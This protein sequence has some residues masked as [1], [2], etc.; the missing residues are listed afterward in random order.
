MKFLPSFF[1]Q[2]LFDIDTHQRGGDQRGNCHRPENR[3][4]AENR[5]QQSPEHR[6]QQRCDGHDQHHKRHHSREFVFGEHIA[7]QRIDNDTGGGGGKTMQEAHPDQLFDRLRQRTGT[8]SDGK[9]QHAP[10]DN[11]LT[12][13]AVRHRSVKQL[14]YRKTQHIGAERHLHTARRN[15]IF[16]R[17]D[18]HTWQIHIDGQ[19]H[20]HRYQ[21]QDENQSDVGYRFFLHFQLLQF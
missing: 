8:G 3:V 19:R 4:P 16:L 18:G 11:R 21:S 2:R 1:R 7:H 5:H 15:T 13:E 9:N 6:R 14:P 17:D 12:P 10:E 20:Q